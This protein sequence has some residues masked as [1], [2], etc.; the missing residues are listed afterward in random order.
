MST[1]AELAI[2]GVGTDGSGAYWDG[3]V[4]PAGTMVRWMHAAGLGFPS[5]GYELER[6]PVPD[7]AELYWQPQVAVVEGR[8][9]FTFP[10]IELSSDQPLSFAGTTPSARLVVAAGAVLRFRFPAP[11]WWVVVHAHPTSDELIVEGLARGV[12]RISRRIHGGQELD[13]RTRGLDEIRVRGAGA[14]A[15]IKYQ[16]ID[17]LRRWEHVAHLCLPVL[18]QGYPCAPTGATSNEV[19]A[20]SRVPASVDWDTRYAA[21]YPQ[22]DEVLVALATGVAPSG[23]GPTVADP[24][25]T[26]RPPTGTID[27]AGLVELLAID[28]HV[29]RMLGLLYDD[30]LALDGR[31]WAYRVT[32]TWEP[33]GAAPVQ[34]EAILPYVVAA[35]GGPPPRP[36]WLTADIASPGG[37]ARPPRA[38]L[39]WDTV[40]GADLVTGGTVLYQLAAVQLTDETQPVPPFNADY[41]LRGG[42]PVAVLPGAGPERP[43]AFDGPLSEGP[44]AWWVRG[45]DLF[46]RVSAPSD[47]AAGMVRDDAVPPPPIILAAEYVQPDVDAG[48]ARL[49]GRTA[50]GEAWA[51]A[52]S[53]PAV[54]VTLAWPPELADRAPDV[55]AFRIHARLPAADG[56]WTTAW[57][58]AIATVGPVPPIV[59]G[60]VLVVGST[61]G[62]LTVRA[63]SLLD[64]THSRCTTDLR[65]DVAGAVV[66]AELEVD[67]TGYPVTAAGEGLAAVL[68]VSHPEGAPPAPGPATLHAAV[69]GVLRVDTTITPPSLS[70]NPHRIRTAGT[71]T[72]SAGRLNVLA[73]SGGAFLVAAPTGGPA[74]GAVT[75]WYPSYRI[76]V[77]D[78]GFGPR[79]SAVTPQAPAQVMVISV[80]RSSTR[81]VESSPSS[82]GTVQAVSVTPPQPP[83]LT[84]IPAGDRCAQVATAADW[85]GTSRFVFTW[86]PVDDVVGH[87]VYRAMDDAVRQADTA[88]HGTGAGALR[89]VFSDSALPAD[90]GRRA[91]ALADLDA[92]DTALGSGD[93]GALRGAYAALR[94]DAWQLIAGQ[95]E[96]TSAF[97]MLNGVPLTLT[98]WE[99]QFPGVPDAHWFYRV[100]CRGASGLVSALSPSTPPICAPRTT[101][102][103]PPRALLALAADAAVTLRFAPSPSVDVVRYRVFRTHDRARAVDVRDMLE[104]VAL[105]A[106]PSEPV[107][108][109]DILPVVS[110]SALAWT[111]AAATPG[112]E[113][114]YRILAEDA[115]GNRSTPSALLSARSLRPAPAAPSWMPA[116]RAGSTVTL[117]WTH[118]D[119]RTAARI[120]RRSPGGLWTGVTRGWLPRGVD[121]FDD[122]PPDPRAAWE[123]RLAV[124][125]RS[126]QM[127]AEMPV[128][129]L[130]EL[131]P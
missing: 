4:P 109:E 128:L 83:A 64:A 31:A 12:V 18:D 53:L 55:D 19:I 43:M 97:T 96:V 85:Y 2:F 28:P 8:L 62:E 110:G 37:A 84:A 89:H 125:D 74:V 120:E 106:S 5:R 130:P 78:T 75:A 51:S 82:P 108:P 71:L 121:T 131:L 48:L 80:R 6:A 68:V 117:A 73:A 112:S 94:A 61:L 58:S 49:L 1:P 93:D 124:R 59:A 15:T 116:V 13:L 60:T 35:P 27:P 25:S 66:G 129:V 67:A 47:P 46:G 63:V 113:W 111:D 127:A 29:A 45:V 21:G 22:L 86:L 99:D 102:P 65:L 52:N 54:I 36:A 114:H 101:P 41:L 40:S 42:I 76:A 126:E 79:A 7:L 115:W 72:T 17:V 23:S 122:E 107:R 16:R 30:N 57:G 34:R 105:S 11:A 98:M 69:S 91:A 50:A 38:A 20:R 100:A 81:P 103:R 14:V 88:A 123:Y 44:R 39:R 70:S 3:C 32:G 56:P 92:L 119:P 104:Q 24:S 87:H 26:D 33:K 90:V 77:A 118:P 95:A 9:S 10:D